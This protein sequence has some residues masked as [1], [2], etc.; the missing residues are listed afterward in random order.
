MTIQW[1]IYSIL[2]YI[3]LKISTSSLQTSVLPFSAATNKGDSPV[4]SALFLCLIFSCIYY[5]YCQILEKYS[6]DLAKFY[7]EFSLFLKI[8]LNLF[9]LL[10]VMLRSAPNLL[11][12]VSTSSASPWIQ[13]MWRGVRSL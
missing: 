1:S 10:Q 12:S 13:E 3:T 2:N 5:I 4:K 9:F 11:T 7:K 6:H 8:F